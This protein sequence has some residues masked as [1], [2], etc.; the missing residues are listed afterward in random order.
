MAKTTKRTYRKRKSTKKSKKSMRKYTP[1]LITKAIQPRKECLAY[2]RYSDVLYYNADLV[3]SMSMVF[4]CNSVFD[5]SSAVTTLLGNRNQQPR[6]RDQ[7]AALYGHY[8]VL[9]SRIRVMVQNAGVVAGDNLQFVL[10]KRGNNMNDTI[11]TSASGV[12]QEHPGRLGGGMLGLGRGGY[13]QKWASGW[14]SEKEFN[15][16]DRL[17]NSANSGANPTPNPEF[18]IALTGGASGDNVDNV[19]VQVIIDYVT[20]WTQPQYA[21]TS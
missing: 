20:L 12:M 15:R 5:P 8:R 2:H 19:Q 10:Y 21:D 9:K 7:M 3:S 4:R 16:Y 1:Y 17:I 18:V 14:W 11:P 6:Y 13:S